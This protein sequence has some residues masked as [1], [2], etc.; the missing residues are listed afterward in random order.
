MI[1]TTGQ[2][3]IPL[4]KKKLILMLIGSIAFVTAGLWFVINPPTISNPFFGNPTVILVTGIASILFFGLCAVYIARKLPDNKPGL[5]IDNIGLTD[6]S[7]GV[8]AGQIL[9]SD[10]ENISVIEIHRQKLI[11]LQVK[12]PQ[13]YIDKQTSSFKRKM[14]QMNFSMYGTPLSITS[15]ALQIKFD[16]LL[17]ILND[18][19]NASRQ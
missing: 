8:S 10:I 7:S 19:L 14:M 17:N 6:N 18:H 13:D 16:E 3:E 2:I 9:W 1:S 11:M 12:N 4:S 15:N 5:I